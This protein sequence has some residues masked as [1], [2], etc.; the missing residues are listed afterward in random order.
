MPKRKLLSEISK[1]HYRRLKRN[2]HNNAIVEN[3]NKLSANFAE[4]HEEQN[5]SDVIVHVISDVNCEL[6]QARNVE[7]NNELSQQYCNVSYNEN[8]AYNLNCTSNSNLE[9]LCP[10]A[11]IYNNE[12]NGGHG[13]SST[14][15]SIK[16]DLTNWAVQ[17]QIT[18]AAVTA[19]LLILRNHGFSNLP[20]SSKTLMKT[21]TYTNIR[22]VAPGEYFHNGLRSGLITFLQ[23]VKTLI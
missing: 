12:K 22:K 7:L 18:H 2:T 23:K 6:D 13:G 14:A 5:S 16:D 11:P 4:I 21:P 20:K 9:D 17:F 8:V 3:M 15:A 1:R 10:I 19:L